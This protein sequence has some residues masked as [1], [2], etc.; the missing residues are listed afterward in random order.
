MLIIQTF[1]AFLATFGFGI[2]FNIKGKK[3]TRYLTMFEDF[4]KNYKE[5]ILQ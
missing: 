2:I 5:G 4:V 1:S 3:Q